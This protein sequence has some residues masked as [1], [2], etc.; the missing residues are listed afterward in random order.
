VKKVIHRL[1]TLSGLAALTLL[2][3]VA[4][5]DG[6]LPGSV[7]IYPIQRSRSN[8][9]TLVN[10]TNTN[11]LPANQF[12]LGGTTAVHYE[13]VNVTP[14]PLGSLVALYCTVADRV[15]ILTP[16]DTY[17]S[18]TQCLNPTPDA[19]GYLVV[20]AQDPSA[21]ATAWS[22]NDL[23]GSE[24]LVD[25]R[26]AVY[27][28]NAL[29]FSSPLP[30]G[31]ATDLDGD[32]QLDFDG[33]EYEGIPDELYVDVFMPAGS[34]SL[35]LINM[36]GG[37]A[38]TAVVA[39]DVW[40]DNEF[41]LS[42]TVA[43][44]CW[45]EERLNKLSLVFDHAFLANNTPNDPTEIDMYCSG[46]G[47]FEAGWA[48]VRGLNASSSVESIPDPA[49]LGAMTC[50]SKPTFQLD[51]GHLLWESYELQSNGDFLKTGTDDPEH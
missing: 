6:R 17:S 15:E 26:G 33:M 49:L 32:Q 40:N 51:T 39:M 7:L 3:T 21:F 20:T 5:A 19:E 2:C 18:L 37:T 13:F 25:G 38:F 34:P 44:R 28:L 29:P 41:A 35:T 9:F 43:F 24:L 27:S 4:S 31:T 36:T 47:Q 1:R 46:T 50:R 14:D 22:H 16:A 10:V 48:R 12:A 8:C 42:A 23:V 45:F 11:T 30:A